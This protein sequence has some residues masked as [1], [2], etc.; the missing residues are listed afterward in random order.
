GSLEGLFQAEAA[1]AELDGETC[2]A[3]F[4]G[5]HEGRGIEIFAKRGDI[6][7]NQPRWGSLL[8]RIRGLESENEPVEAHGKPDPGGFGS[9]EGLAQA[10]I[11]STANQRILRAQARV[12]ELEGGSRV[13]V[14]ATNKAV[15][16]L[17]GN[18]GRI[19]GRC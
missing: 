7:V 5:Q 1:I 10:A 18:A 13:I 17:V 12:R 2:A 11:G 6:G 9:A 19:E 4:A 16:Q 14:E 15:V 8:V 3:Q